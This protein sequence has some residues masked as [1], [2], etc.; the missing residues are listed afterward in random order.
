MY[1][2][3][4]GKDLTLSEVNR[5]AAVI[6]DMVDPQCNIIFGAVIDDAYEGDVHVTLIATGFEQAFENEIWPEGGAQQQSA[7]EAA[8]S[9]P[10][11]GL[12]D[13][14]RAVG[15]AGHSRRSLPF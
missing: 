7:R 8:R 2:I 5:V 13:N 11:A 6:S 12:F 9:Q 15:G 14:K 1:N 10:P 4:G 3:T